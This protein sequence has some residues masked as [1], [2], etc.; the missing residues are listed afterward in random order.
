MMKSN[1][2]RSSR[3]C[4][5]GLE[6]REQPGSIMTAG[7]DPSLL[8][9]SFLGKGLLRVFDEPVAARGITR[10]STGVVNL[11]ETG[12]TIQPPAFSSD[13]D[14]STPTPT[15]SVV[16]SLEDVFG[17]GATR[18]DPSPT[19]GPEAGMERPGDAGTRGPDLLFY[20]GDADGRAGWANEYNTQ[21]S[22]ARVYDDVRVR[23]DW[24]M[25]CLFSHNVMN[26]VGVQQAYVHIIGPGQVKR[27]SPTAAF[28]TRTRRRSIAPRRSRPASLT[29]VTR[30]TKSRLVG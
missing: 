9:G 6:S 2:W 10:M 5:E 30:I 3:P 20:A 4:V 24:T 11:V 25:D 12:G 15:N 16:P 21:V 18:S 19:I 13:L 27:V 26:F 28:R 7:F 22:D 29:T 17:H 1:V 23:A 8:A 14:V